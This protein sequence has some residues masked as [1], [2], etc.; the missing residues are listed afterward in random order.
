LVA[1][2]SRGALPALGALDVRAHEHR[3]LGADEERPLRLPGLW[4]SSKR[5]RPR[6]LQGSP[7]DRKDRCHNG[8][9]GD[10]HD[11]ENERLDLRYPLS[12]TH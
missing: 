12:G 10:E 6:A 8:R 1:V 11:Y 5:K 9:R 3:R 4:V 7:H 2:R